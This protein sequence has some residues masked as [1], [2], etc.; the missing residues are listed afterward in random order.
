MSSYT[1]LIGAVFFAV[2]RLL[3]FFAFFGE[4]ARVHFAPFFRTDLARILLHLRY[5]L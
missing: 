5:V 4:I 2:L 3:L 1:A